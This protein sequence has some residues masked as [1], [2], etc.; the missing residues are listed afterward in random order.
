MSERADI[1]VL[2][3]DDDPA[4]AEVTAEFLEREND[5]FTVETATSASEGLEHLATDEFD[6]V[7]SDYDMPGENGIEFLE[8]VRERAP[9]LPFVLFTGKGSEE[10]AGR[11]ISAGVT[12]YLQK[13]SG[14]DQYTVLANRLQNA[15]NRYRAETD[16]RRQRKAVETAQEGISILTEDGEYIYVNRA[17]ADIYG[18]DP[19]EM[20]GRDWEL[21]CPEDKVAVTQDVIMPTVA[22]DGYWSGE[23]TGLRADGTTFL[24]DH[25][26]ART[27]TGELICSVRDKSAEQEREFELT[28]FRT[29]VETLSDPV[30]ILDDDG[31]FEYVNDAFV[32]MVGYDRETL[33]GS[34]TALI[35]QPEAIDR[36]KTNLGRILSSNGPDS[37]QF[38]IEVQPKQGEPIVCEDHMGVLPYDGAS[39]EGS[40]GILRDITE[41]KEREAMLRRYQYAYESALSGIAITDL[42]G[43]L[44]D[45]NPAFLDMWGYDAKDDVVGRPAMDMWDDP[46]Q[47]MSVLETITE[48]GCREDELKAVR[49]DGSTFYARGVNS[50][51]TESD[52]NP[53]GVI[54]SFFDIT[55]RKEREAELEMQSAAMEA[56]MDGISILNEDGEYVYMNQAHADVFDYDAE[57][58]LGSTWQRLYDDDETARLEQEVFPVLERNGEWRGETV[59]QRRDG[60]PVYQ[61]ITLSLLDDDKLICTN[62]DITTR[63]ERE[64]EL[65]RTSS[66]LRTIVESLPMGVLV[67]DTER[68]VLMAN[69]RLGETLGAPIDGEELIGRDCAVA[70]EDLK[71]LFADPEGFMQGISERLERRAQVQN[72]ELPLADGRVVARDYVPY[73]LP[74]GEAHLWLYRDVT[75]RKQQQRALERSNRFLERTQSVASVGG[76]EVD[77]RTESLQWTDEVYR[78]H[79]VDTDFEPTVEDAIDL[80]HPKD[81]ATI[82]DAFEQVTTEGEPYDVELRIVTTSDE[83]RWVHTRGEPLY[84]DGEIVG[85]RG[86]FQD[87]TERM[88][89]KR[90]L[91]EFVSVV[92]HDIRNPLNIATA[93]LTLAAEECNSAHLDDVEG[94]LARIE[95]LV[96]DLLTL[97]REGDDVTDPQVVDLAAV[98]TEC[99]GTVETRQA[100]LQHNIDRRVLADESRLKQIFENLFRNAVEHGGADVTV[101]VGGLDDG[102]Y[103]EDDGRGIPADE[104]DSVFK[105]G[106]SQSTDG[107]GFGLSIIEQVVDAHDWQVRV[108]DGTAGGARFE[109]TN[110]ESVTT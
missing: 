17:Y 108:T 74:E 98:A 91:E 15:V 14:T 19:D 7:V 78:I 41:Q 94:A 100:T 95:T 96:D 38:E 26:V 29:L 8:S 89:R 3:V 49:A 33:I 23:T 63:K 103:I 25:T 4:F 50:H 99:W 84:E 57:E 62:R 81:R 46:E 79:G 43:E 5:S 44:V 10:I 72:E 102:F 65:E 64:Q 36:S 86:T 35:K 21:T 40:V 58:L 101:T 52:G 48:Q 73:T 30:Y 56:S 24:E 83:V 92:S 60:S 106:Y 67:E 76:W 68:D 6:C 39:F 16:R 61:E 51:L 71:D 9:D 109:I 1:Y 34:S 80:Y 22:E 20:T 69:D 107:T 93:R 66:V 53:I 77:L 18:Y 85:V 2:H 105:N 87:T 31:Q 13:Q 11:A 59:G 75:A 97:A 104:R 27:D 110:V 28:R 45:V 32:E 54:A 70:A 88:E 82:E 37:V 90:K 12:D 42:D 55:E 47:A